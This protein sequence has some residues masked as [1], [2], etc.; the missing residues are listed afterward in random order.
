[1]I[2]EIKDGHIA[3]IY[4]ESSPEPEIDA[5][6]CYVLP[7]LTDLHTHGIACESCC[8]ESL[9]EY[10]RIEASFGCTTFFPTLFGPPAESA[11]HMRRHRKATDGF[12]LLPQIGGFRLESPYL[13]RAGGGISRDLAPISDDTTDML[14]EA[15]GGHI[16]IWDVSPEL[17]DSLQLISHLSSKGIVC[18]IAHTHATID[19][20]KQ[21]VDSGARLVTHLFD[22]F[23]TPEMTD[24]GVYPVGLPDYLLTEDRV[25]CEIITDGTHVHPLLIEKTLR[26]K[27]LDKTIFVTDS[28][29]GAGLPPGVYD[30]PH[31][32]GRAAIDGPNNG[33]RLVDRDMTLCGSALTPLDALR[34]CIRILG[35][36]I[37]TASWLCSTNP[38]KLLGLN[39]GVMALGMD[40]DLIILDGKLDL[41]HTIHGGKVIYSKHTAG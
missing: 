33:V 32:W 38:A 15:G 30:L 28:N 22:T 5:T 27:P 24:P 35:E 19:C 23:A 26:C 29:F 1:M 39:K 4:L 34:N 8:S 6:G 16:K 7:S 11:A 14:L 25:A 17:E 13:A 37:V 31:G 18:S 2:F 20:A 3:D 9:E 41:L 12:R 10:A 21:A 36:D 40:A